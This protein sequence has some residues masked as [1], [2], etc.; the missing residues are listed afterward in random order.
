MVH[1]RAKPASG[2]Q[3]GVREVVLYIRG[4]QHDGNQ[5]WAPAFVLVHPAAEPVSDTV[6]H[7]VQPFSPECSVGS[8]LN[9]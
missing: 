5:A 8:V 1:S 3:Q 4:R 7:G 6:L 9:S 2:L